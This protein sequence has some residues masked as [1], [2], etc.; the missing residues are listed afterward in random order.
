RVRL[1][2][3]D[4][5]KLI[6]DEGPLDKN[7]DRRVPHEALYATTDPV[8]MDTIGWNEVEKWRK[9]KHLPSLVK[10]GREPTYI[11]VAGEL[12]L[13]IADKDQ[14]RLREVTL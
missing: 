6:Y 12:G 9:D 5:F 13:G 11:R 8:A 14:I 7:P 3:T 2:I 10:A 1:H 4:G